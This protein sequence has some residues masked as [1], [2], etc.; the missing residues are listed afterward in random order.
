VGWGEPPVEAV[1]PRAIVRP[2]S[3]QRPLFERVVVPAVAALPV[4]AGQRLGTVVVT[5]GSRVVARSPLVAA[6][7]RT[8]PTFGGRAW[9]VTRRTAH[10]FLGLVP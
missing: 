4:R 6:A 7:A 1:A 2:A 3:V 10:R 8:A 5:D 9:W